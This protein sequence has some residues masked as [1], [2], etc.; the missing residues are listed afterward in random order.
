MPPPVTLAEFAAHRLAQRGRANPERMTNAV[1][2]W[3][4]RTRLSAYQ[5]A[6][7]F[8][9]RSFGSPPGWCFDRFGCSMTVLDD[10]RVVRIAGEHEDAYD[11]DFFI[12]NDVVVL[13]PDGAIDVLGYSPDVFPPTD[14]HTATRVGDHVYLI[15]NLGYPD[16]RRQGT[17]QVLRLDIGSL[18][19]SR[20]PSAP[21]GGPGW[22]HEH[23]AE[24]SPD[25]AA[26]IVR[27]GIVERTTDGGPVLVDNIDDWAYHLADGSWSRLTRRPWQQWEVRRVD[28][29]PLDLFAMS[30]MAFNADIGEALTEP[31]DIGSRRFDPAVYA[32]LFRPATDHQFIERSFDDDADEDGHR[33][34]D[35]TR[36]DEARLAIGETIVRYATDHREVV[37][38]IEGSLSEDATRAIVDDLVDKLTR[39]QVSPCEARRV[40]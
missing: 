2:S 23:R 15:G 19:L 32:A 16:Q 18:A 26:I 5:A 3:L 39:L 36:H 14:F 10:G 38:K 12:Y 1:W 4:V 21:K 13:H 22:I 7:E 17:T 11:P 35:N 6:A 25:G 9:E 27:R 33:L 34:G 29:E 40:D 28:R 30:C 24:L 8:G 20:A 31:E 37:I